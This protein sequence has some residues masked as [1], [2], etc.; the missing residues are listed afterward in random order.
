[1]LSMYNVFAFAAILFATV[2]GQLQIPLVCIAKNQVNI[3]HTL[4]SLSQVN[5]G[6]QGSF[7]S[8]ETLSVPVNTVV[9][10]EFFGA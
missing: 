6:L 1:M 7:Y 3:F 2:V 5:V 9:T 4:N 8:P 10:F